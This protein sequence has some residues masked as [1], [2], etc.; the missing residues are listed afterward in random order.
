MKKRVFVAAVAVV[1]IVAV[2]VFLRDPFSS[3]S[4]QNAAVAP[5]AKHSTKIAARAMLSPASAS[6][7]I[8]RPMRPV[9]PLPSTDLALAIT[10]EELKRRAGQGEPGAMCRL[11]AEYDH[12]G[13]LPAYEAGVDSRMAQFQRLKHVDTPEARSKVA[14]LAQTIPFAQRSADKLA[15]HCKGVA[16][17]E[18]AALM[19]LWRSAALSGDPAALA[20]Y[21]SGDVLRGENVLDLQQELA[22]Y[23]NE[24][25]RMATLGAQRG[26]FDL[27]RQLAESYTVSYSNN[28]SLLA[29]AV[30]P[31]PGRALA[32]YRRIAATLSTA[33]HADLGITREVAHR[34]EEL[35]ISIGDEQLQRAHRIA[36]EELHS[37]EQ[38]IIREDNLFNTSGMKFAMG[39]SWCGR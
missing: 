2:A 11:A 17:P 37:W 26:D 3:T 34:I 8:P 4:V 7:Y 21:A 20:H 12:C 36:T 15:A 27:M 1:S 19:Q 14:H 10:A 30:R 13:E 38:L 24:A 28:R 18:T 31:D 32:L 25:E 29:Q 16:I 23:K 5:V 35:E 22:T 6:T 39:R 33:G 9:T